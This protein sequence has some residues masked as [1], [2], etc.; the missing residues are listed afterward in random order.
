MTIQHA[1]CYAKI[2]FN[3]IGTDHNPTASPERIID[4]DSEASSGGVSASHINNELTVN[5]AGTYRLFLQLSAQVADDETYTIYAA[6]NDAEAGSIGIDIERKV[7]SLN[8]ITA[9][10]TP[11][12]LVGDTISLY[13]S[14]GNAGGASFIPTFLEIDITKVGL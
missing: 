2:A 7:G 4:F 5:V 1:D 10:F 12:L 8:F 6:I 13:V 3:G 11:S 9:G 14:S